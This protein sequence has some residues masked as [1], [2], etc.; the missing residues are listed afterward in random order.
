MI[1][2][3]RLDGLE[4][5]LNLI[6]NQYNI[7]LVSEGTLQNRLQTHPLFHFVD[8]VLHREYLG[9]LHTRG[10]LLIDDAVSPTAYSSVQPSRYTSYE[11]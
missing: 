10:R 7:A 8:H 2:N 1:G 4:T 3:A 11:D 6:N 5:Q 9:F